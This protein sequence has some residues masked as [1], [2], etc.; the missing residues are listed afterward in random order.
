MIGWL[1]CRL[2]HR[3]FRFVRVVTSVS[4]ARTAYT[5]CTVCG[6]YADASIPKDAS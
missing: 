3:G 1:I 4:G 2:R 5:K 6:R